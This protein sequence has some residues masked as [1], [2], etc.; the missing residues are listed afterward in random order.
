MKTADIVSD[1]DISVILKNAFE[2]ELE[3]RGF[4]LGPGGNLVEVTLV[5]L[6]NH[7]LRS[8]SP[9]EA[10]AKMSINVRVDY[11]GGTVSYNKFLSAY[12]QMA[13]MPNWGVKTAQNVLNGALRNGVSKAFN[14]SAFI[15][16]LKKP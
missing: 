16:A 9:P 13:I 1:T 11:L 5:D 3:E 7:Y 4:T 2:A 12:S 8:L 6:H 10:I 14:D 15:S